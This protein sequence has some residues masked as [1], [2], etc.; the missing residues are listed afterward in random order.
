MAYL[1]DIRAQ[2]NDPNA[3]NCAYE[4]NLIGGTFAIISGHKG[5]YSISEQEIV[6]RVNCGKIRIYGENLKVKC[7]SR[8]EIYVI[9]RI[10]GVETINEN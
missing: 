4:I 3:L 6:S 2:S 9:G 7:V 10:A 8:E 1:S 5:L